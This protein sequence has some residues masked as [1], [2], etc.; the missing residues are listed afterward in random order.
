[1]LGQRRSKLG[2][3]IGNGKKASANG[4]IDNKKKKM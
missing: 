4:R 3:S 2:G 1:M